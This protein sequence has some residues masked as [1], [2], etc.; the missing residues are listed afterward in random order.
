[1][2]KNDYII[3]LD[4]VPAAGGSRGV[5]PDAGPG[6]PLRPALGGQCVAPGP[7][8]GLPALRLGGCRDPLDDGIR[9][10]NLRLGG[11][12]P[13]DQPDQRRPVPDAPV[14]FRLALRHCVRRVLPLPRLA[15]A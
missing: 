6:E 9:R 11:K 5:L 13:A 2:N 8:P 3:R 12:A 10:K 1:M 15:L 7:A 4:P 14:Q